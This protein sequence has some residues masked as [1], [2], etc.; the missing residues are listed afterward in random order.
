MQTKQDRRR[1]K[2]SKNILALARL[3]Q[4]R[5]GAPRPSCCLY[6]TVSYACMYYMVASQRT[7]PRPSPTVL[8]HRVFFVARD[9]ETGRG[10]PS[11][12]PLPLRLL[13]RAGERCTCSYNRHYQY[14]NR[15]LLESSVLYH[16]IE[17][18]MEIG[19]EKSV[20]HGTVLYSR[21][22][23]QVSSCRTGDAGG[24]P[25]MLCYPAQG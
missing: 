10:L 14:A 18:K 22:S 24:E 23:L 11:A 3:P 12:R 20:L 13:D 8:Q 2:G 17:Q 5:R 4:R 6:R 16:N 9:I 25:S 7:K 15:V 21:G 1:N 19:K